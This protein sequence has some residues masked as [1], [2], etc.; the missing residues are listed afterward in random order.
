[1]RVKLS[2]HFALQRA[3]LILGR[4]R[5][6]ATLLAM[7]GRVTPMS[8]LGLA[9]HG[10]GLAVGLAAKD[11][12][13]VAGGWPAV[14][15]PSEIAA[16]VERAMAPTARR[17]VGGWTHCEAPGQELLLHSDGAARAEKDPEAA[18]D[19]LREALWAATGPRA[20][21]R[22]GKGWDHVDLAAS[23]EG[24]AHPSDRADAIWA[25]IRPH[26]EAGEL[27]RLVPVGV[28]GYLL[29]VVTGFCFI[30]TAPAQYLYNPAVQT[31]LSLMAAAGINM[32]VFYATTA[33]A[34][35]RSGALS[36]PA[37]PGRRRVIA[38]AASPLAVAQRASISATLH[39]YLLKHTRFRLGKRVRAAPARQQAML[40]SEVI[41]QRSGSECEAVGMVGRAH[42]SRHPVEVAAGAVLA[43]AGLM[44]HQPL[45]MA[46]AT[47]AVPILQDQTAVVV[48]ALAVLGAT[49]VAVD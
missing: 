5:E 15:V 12:A 40:P 6:T 26:L 27:H 23:A 18:A 38:S 24:A 39:L 48:A 4:I 49:M 21:L 44:D 19:V 3:C 35:A 43:Q 31:K 45:S 13:E 9:T 14:A 42:R 8:V 10:L 25:R 22:P 16:A 32:A 17:S 11:I 47:G 2:H 20:R 34:V 36:A 7:S 1:M 29:C 46:L 30:V 28:A 41:P 33:S 37:A